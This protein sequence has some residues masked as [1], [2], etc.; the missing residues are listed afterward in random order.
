MPTNWKQLKAIEQKNKERILAICPDIQDRSG[1]YMFYRADEDG[2][3]CGRYIGKSETSVWERCASH[4]QGYK[5]HIDISLRKHKLWSESNPTGWQV[6]V[7]EY[8]FPHECDERERYYIDFAVKLG[9]HLHNVESGGT[10]GKTDINDRKP[11]R[12]YRDGVK[13]G[14]KNVIKK[15]AH[16]FDLHLKAVYK[17]DKPSKNAQKAMEKFNE[18]IGA[19][20]ET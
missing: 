2:S 12:G 5:S 7:L 11:S 15:V 16:L 4:L 17:A 1:I 14:E 13:Q 20:D 18:M 6:C 3:I 19:K 9:I 10:I 8:C